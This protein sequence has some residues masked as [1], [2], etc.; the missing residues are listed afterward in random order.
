MVILAF[1]SN[2]K[3]VFSKIKDGALKDR[4]IKQ[5]AKI[6]EDPEIGKPMRFNRKGTREVYIGSCR[7]SYAYLKEE[8]KII[9]LDLYH[10]DKQ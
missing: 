7:L 10:K 8:K 9:F 5:F 3:E 1:H 2:F 6:Q 4:L